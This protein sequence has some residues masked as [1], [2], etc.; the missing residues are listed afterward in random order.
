LR[1]FAVKLIIESGLEIQ[2]GSEV[3][4][5]YSELIL[6]VIIER[7]S[8]VF[9]ASLHNS[10]VGAVGPFETVDQFETVGVVAQIRSSLLNS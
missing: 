9:F 2:V 7:F 5:L 4:R 3:H 10:L 6:H 8:F 1:H